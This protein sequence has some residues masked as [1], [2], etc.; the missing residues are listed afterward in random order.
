[1]STLNAIALLAYRVPDTSTGNIL[2]FA[3][4]FIVM[5]CVLAIVIILVKWL[6]SLGGVTIPQPLLI[7]LGILI[8]IVCMLAL[9]SWSGYYRF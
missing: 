5:V 9:L 7:C 2:H 4:G 1:M 8:F 3:V 6:L